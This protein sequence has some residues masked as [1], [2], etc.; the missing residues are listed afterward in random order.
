MTD[1]MKP[2]NRAFYV[3]AAIAIALNFV[4]TNLFLGQTSLAYALFGTTVIGVILV[5]VI[6]PDTTP[7]DTNN[8]GD[9]DISDLATLLSNFGTSSGATVAQGDTDEDGDVD[10]SDL[11][12]LLS[13]FGTK[14]L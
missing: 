8:D 7:G 4:F 10:I 12:T 13:G 5:P 3:S 2:L 14:F 9:V 1:V 6:A 11:A